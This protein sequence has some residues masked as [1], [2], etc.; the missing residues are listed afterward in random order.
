MNLIRKE[1]SSTVAISL[2]YVFNVLELRV[3]I[4]KRAIF[5]TAKKMKENFRQIRHG[6][7]SEMYNLGHY[8]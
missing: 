4:E 6:Q 5:I 2:A 3:K 1:G 8:H 7:N